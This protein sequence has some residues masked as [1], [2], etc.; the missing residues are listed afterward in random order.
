MTHAQEGTAETSVVK[1]GNVDRIQQRVRERFQDVQRILSLDNY[2]ELVTERPG[3]QLRNAAQYLVN[4]FE[5][6]G[7]DRLERFGQAT[8]RFKLFDGGF[9]GGSDFLAGQEGVQNEI[10]RILKGLA[11]EGRTDKLVLL[12]GPNGS[13]KTTVINLIFRGLEHYSR[14]DEGALYQFAWIFPKPQ[15]SEDRLGFSRERREVD[16]AAA[17]T[18]AFLPLEDVAARIPCELRDSPL[19]LV[20]RDERLAFLRHALGVDRDA[21]LQ[22]KVSRHILEG[23][24]DPKSKAIYEGLL[25]GYQ[26]DWK[27][28]VRHIQVERFFLSH[29]FRTGAVRIDPQMHVDA[30]GRQVTMDRSVESLPAMLMN[31]R[32]VEPTGDLVDANHGVLEYS[33]FLKRP[34]DMNKYLLS[35]VETG[36]VSLPGL[37]MHLDLVFFGT[38]NENHL[39]AFKK[40]MDYTS[41]KARMELVQVPYLM[42][43]S[44]EESIY[45]DVVRAVSRRKPVLPHTLRVAA[46]WAVMTRLK[47]PNK[48]HYP[49]AVQGLI[50]R[51]APLEKARLYDNGKPPSWMKE[52]DRKRIRQFVGFMQREFSDDV[53]YEGRFGAS[54]REI[55]A[56][57]NEASHLQAFSC[58]GPLAVF[59]V[60]DDFVKE[61]NVY[62][63]LNL[64]PEGEYHDPAGF[65]SAIR[66]EY[67]A[68]ITAELE[69]AMDLVDVAEYDRK[70]NEYFSHVVA[71]SQGEKVVNPNTGA[72]EP[73][74]DAIMGGVERLLDLQESAEDFR[75][76]LVA[77][78]GAFRI[79]HPD[80]PVV[81]KELFPD[82]Y[83]AF[84]HD[85]F[86]RRRE[87]IHKIEEQVLCHLSGDEG[88]VRLDTKAKVEQTIANLKT[89]FGY[90]DDGIQEVVQFIRKHRKLDP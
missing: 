75:K 42:R 25:T 72:L 45:R 12:H 63:F 56:I 7:N 64:E 5:Y 30:G 53:L 82:I 33:D 85:F 60:L 40:T 41:F 79:D 84:K 57:L 80:S 39:D 87:K 18:Y 76:N 44:D 89:Q 35:T 88:G 36:E 50:D 16:A 71:F 65:I 37:F 19:F 49:E 73:P 78:I 61:V 34:V 59:A 8:E 90:C 46:M 48:D 13:S 29:R 24:L 4:M 43:V 26:G 83:N 67:H 58:L 31:V 77:R 68:W 28:V 38:T 14:T 51:L 10:Y 54:P 62:D 86:T 66:D 21:D 1:E 32:L 6:F 74:S 70:S 52:E 15:R 81:Y 2:L 22:K 11:E 9:P 20:P 27:K 47:K 69:D 55:R 23:D 3:E 17:D